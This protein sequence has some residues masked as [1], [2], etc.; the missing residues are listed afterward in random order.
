MTRKR[1]IFLL[2]PL[3]I[4]LVVVFNWWNA[5]SNRVQ[6]SGEQATFE[7]DS[8]VPVVYKD[9]GVI[10]YE[11]TINPAVNV[12]LT[13]PIDGYLMPGDYPLEVG[14]RIRENDI[15]FK[16]DLRKLFKELSAKKKELKVLAERLDDEL[17]TNHADQKDIWDI[18]TSNLLPTKRLPGF[19]SF[20][21]KSKNPLIQS[22]TKAYD[23]VVRIE[24]RT[25]VYYVF[26]PISG[27][28]VSVKKKIGERIRAG[29]C[30][31]QMAPF[32]I[33]LAQFKVPKDDVGLLQLKD[34]VKLTSNKKQL[35]GRIIK[36]S[37]SKDGTYATVECSLSKSVENR[38]EKIT[39][40]LPRNS[41]Y[42]Y[43]PSYVL[44]NDSVWISRQGRSMKIPATILDWEKDSVAVKELKPGDVVL[45]KTL[46]SGV[47][48]CP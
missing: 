16:L 1:I 5:P 17:K 25:E 35:K 39:L 24:A 23:E 13:F 21:T 36:I 46:K 3:V 8:I 47:I 18:F 11:G 27:T 26:A 10:A 2:I 15:L 42:F 40:Q 44:R 12:N 4:V 6:Q 34:E 33:Y 19:P 14:K 20:L 7:V 29:E 45:R 43:I 31:A 37:M 32:Q 22:F 9:S 48:A 30:V 28:I 41:E 38:S